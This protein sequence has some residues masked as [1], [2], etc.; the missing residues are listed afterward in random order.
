MGRIL[1]RGEAGHNIIPELYPLPTEPVIDKPGKGA[2]F[3]T[4]LHAILRN[5]GIKQLIVTG[6]TTE[7]CRHITVREANDRGYDCLVPEDCVGSYFP[8][9]QQAGLKMIKAQSSAGSPT[10]QRS[11]PRCNS[12][13]HRAPPYEGGDWNAF[14]GFGTNILVNL[15]TLSGLLRFVFKMPDHLVFR[16]IRE[17]P[18]TARCPSANHYRLAAHRPPDRHLAPQMRLLITQFSIDLHCRPFYRCA[19]KAEH[20]IYRYESIQAGRRRDID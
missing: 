14:L 2:F 10:R 19:G 8:E 16:R 20:I 1:V 13:S 7:V 4:D 5:R 12:H 3:A 17:R 6:V 18:R 9:F 15:L 11:S